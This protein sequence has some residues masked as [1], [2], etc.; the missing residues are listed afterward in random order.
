MT[1][2]IQ[3][4]T[5]NGLIDTSRPVLENM[6]KIATAAG[7]WMTFDNKTGLWSVIINQS[8]ESQWSFDHSNILGGIKVSGTG[9]FDLYNSVRVTYPRTDIRDNE[10]FVQFELPPDS[11]NENEPDNTLEIGLDF[12]TNQAQAQ[13]IALRELKQSRIDQIITFDTDYT[14]IGI[15]AGDIIDVT[16]SALGLVQSLYRVV[17]VAERD[18]ASQGIVLNI[19]ALQ[20]SDDVYDES[21]LSEYTRST[22][23]GIVAAGDIGKPAAP[24][25]TK[26]ERAARPKINAS[27]TV[28]S[29]R[30]EGMEVWYTTDTANV[31]ADRKYDYVTTTEPLNGGLYAEN[32]PVTLVYSDL[33]IANLYVKV[34]GVNSTTT[35]PFSDPS[36]L[37]TFQP[38]QTTA[39]INE[40]TVARNSTTGNLLTALALT[41]LLGK[42][43]GLFS[44]V[45]NAGSLFDQV[46]DLFG[47]VTGVDLI[48]QATSGKLGTGNILVGDIG[49]VETIP[50]T[51]NVTFLGNVIYENGYTDP[52]I[53]MI[54]NTTSN[55]VVFSSSPGTAT[56]MW[57]G[58]GQMTDDLG[59][60]V[61]ELYST[62]NFDATTNAG[63]LYI[64]TVANWKYSGAG[65]LD[66]FK[67]FNM[68]LSIN[69]SNVESTGDSSTLS[70]AYQNQVL[71]M[72]YTGNISV[73]DQIELHFDYASDVATGIAIDYA[74]FQ[75]YSSS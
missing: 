23:T 56:Q 37:V 72:A 7:A 38:E 12:V 66:T 73:N 16:D 59:P 14:S 63:S 74:I 34:R 55:T 50:L 65:T 33:D 51:G 22:E 36:G 48:N 32:D 5:V 53:Y 64:T 6:E 39:A 15:R 45:S 69:G 26:T 41:T 10:D 61:G 62:G 17:T 75:P 11:R 29:G 68:T 47:N 20:Y 18:D 71:A 21:D 60:F 44:N 67:S 43:D 1:N 52:R 28:P 57:V 25:I 46:F 49:P 54:G 4:N 9:L 30:V 70:D 3:R 42:V 40:L 35:G 19:T 2:T 13:L 24:T 27:F 58:T 8:G 31:E